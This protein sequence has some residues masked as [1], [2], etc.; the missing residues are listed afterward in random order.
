MV[1]GWVS[2]ILSFEYLCYTVNMHSNRSLWPDWARFL[3]RWGL[4]DVVAYTLEAAG[5]LAVIGAQFLYLG[6]PF[7]RN[8]LPEG[9]VSALA[10]LLED[11]SEAKNFAAFLRE[12][13]HL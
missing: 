4:G 12:E 3:Q 10:D 1:V 8:A 13:K 11:S 2:W 9:H 5:P 6:Q 7:F